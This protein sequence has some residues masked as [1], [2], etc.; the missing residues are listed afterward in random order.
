V[1]ADELII[2]RRVVILDLDYVLLQLD[3]RPRVNRHRL[4]H[5]RDQGLQVIIQPRMDAASE[6][7]RRDLG[8]HRLVGLHDGATNIGGASATDRDLPVADTRL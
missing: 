5:V 7:W 6:L 1:L 4:V 2:D 8:K 3:W